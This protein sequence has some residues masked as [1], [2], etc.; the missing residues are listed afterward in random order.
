MSLSRPICVTGASGFIGR[1]L[2]AAL[3]ARGHQV[4][5]CARRPF[6]APVGVQVVTVTHYTDAPPADVLIHLA[7]PAAVP[8]DAIEG[9]VTA[10]LAA[11][12]GRGYRRLVYLSSA[13]VYGDMEPYPRRP[14]E[15]A[16]AENGYGRMKRAGEAVALAAEGVVVR[17]TN[18]Y[19]PGMS[20][21][22]VIADILAQR[23]VPGPIRLRDLAPVR[24]YL[25]RDDAVA[26]L[27][28]IAEGSATGVFNLGSGE[29]ASVERLA[30]TCLRLWG[31]EGDGAV[32]TAPG[33]RASILRLDISETLRQFDW[34][35]RI[36]L[37]EGLARLAVGEAA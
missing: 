8:G 35:P 24:D 6:A 12:A 33:D 29:A 36:A 22:T 23:A 10:T 7:E 11:L 28:A 9:A 32:A 26:G 17:L 19:G 2:S 37:D 34:R 30:Q 27:V 31:R 25:W 1:A 4:L 3:S 14:D 15:P 5:A 21:G 20:Q 13:A 18:V 16:R